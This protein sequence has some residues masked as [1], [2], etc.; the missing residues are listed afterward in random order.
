MSIYTDSKMKEYIWNVVILLSLTFVLGVFVT[1][2]Q[3]TPAPK[4]PQQSIAAAD[5][6]L[7]G[8]I[9]AAATA[10]Q[11]GRLTITQSELFRARAKEA[12]RV[13]NAAKTALKAGD[14]DLAELNVKD[15]R[16]LLLVLNQLLLEL[17]KSNGK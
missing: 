12:E 7:T 2:C 16:N 5:I 6:A 15:V 10:K 11:A 4:T 13:L 8:I 3:T 9:N 17:E 14:I 1:G